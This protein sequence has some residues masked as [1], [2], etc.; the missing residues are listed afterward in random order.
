M[1]TD[2][3]TV[4]RARELRH[5][6]TRAE[7][8]LWYDFLS[9]H[10]LH[11]RRQHPIVYYILD[12]YCADARLAIEI[13]GA[14]HFTEEGKALDKVRTEL[15]NRYG[16]QVIRF[17]NNQIEEYFSAVCGIIERVLRE[18]IQRFQTTDEITTSRQ[19][20]PSV[21]ASGDSSPCDGEP[22]K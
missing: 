19:G 17:T 22:L 2:A 1:L 21:T 9:K 16:I 20:N 15:L 8:H 12:F 7:K 11:F 3:K 5:N 13:D 6:M 10:P 4:G 18:R 14:G